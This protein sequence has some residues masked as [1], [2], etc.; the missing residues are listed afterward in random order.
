MRLAPL[1]LVLTGCAP[2]LVLPPVAASSAW[3]QALEP[4]ALVPAPAADAPVVRLDFD[5]A[6][7]YSRRLV[8]THAGIYTGWVQKPQIS[9]FA[10]SRGTEAPAHVPAIIGL[11]FRTLEP[12]AVTGPQLVLSCAALADTIPLATASRV[13]ATGNT[14]SHFLTYLLPT[15]RVVA[16]ASCAQGSMQVGQT[17]ATFSPSQLGGL[18]ALL[19]ALGAGA[20]SGVT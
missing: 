15:A 17:A 7:G 9:F 8:T 20:A 10:L 4:T 5:T 6:S 1:V 16:F 13:A 11:V 2:A 18:R 3:D 19:R 12:D 14:H